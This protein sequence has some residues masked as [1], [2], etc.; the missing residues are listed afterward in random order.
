MIIFPSIP[1]DSCGMLCIPET[2]D[3]PPEKTE[4]QEQEEVDK[5]VQALIESMS[6]PLRG[7]SHG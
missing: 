6:K 7:G 5:F 4:E 1:E 2:L 3:L